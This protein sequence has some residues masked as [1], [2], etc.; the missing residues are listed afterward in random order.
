M[1][2]HSPGKEE[3]SSR[4]KREWGLGSLPFTLVTP[5]ARGASLGG[6]PL[7]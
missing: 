6:S 2:V 4:G 5:R 3:M 7:N 1:E